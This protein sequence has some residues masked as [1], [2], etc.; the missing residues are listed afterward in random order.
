MS[1]QLGNISKALL[2]I[3]LLLLSFL[4][5]HA[6]QTDT[7]RPSQQYLN[8]VDIA[9]SCMNVEDWKGAEKYIT[10]ALRT[11]PANPAN[12]LLFSNL[13]NVRTRMQ[14]FEGAIQAFDIALAR[15]PK[16]TV[17]LGNKASALLQ[18]ERYDEALADLSTALESDS[19]LIWHRE[20]RASI[21]LLQNNI[22]AAKADY[23]YLLDIDNNNPDALLGKAQ[24]LMAENLP[25][26]ALPLYTKSAELHPSQPA[27]YSKTLCLI[28]LEKLSEARKSA[29][30]TINAFPDTS[31]N[32][33]L[34]AYVNHL[35]HLPQE[36]ESALHIAK[37]MGATDKEIRQFFAN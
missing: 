29:I 5:L 35:L 31:V 27:L 3:T 30:D 21:Y 6:E 8:Y 37:Q 2:P 11:E 36:S 25:E 33:I 12:M 23:D 20:V 13:G 15:A 17:I 24:C 16:S 22:K 26:Q 9:D 19:S 4:Y 28:Q 34:L 7:L 1:Q 18:A 14:D 10:L 32:Y